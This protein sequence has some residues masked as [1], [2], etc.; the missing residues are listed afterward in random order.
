MAGLAHVLHHIGGGATLG[1]QIAQTQRPT[2]QHLH[3]VGAVRDDERASAGA[4]LTH[5]QRL[6]R[7]RVGLDLGAVRD[8]ELAIAGLAATFG[9]G[10]LCDVARRLECR[11][12]ALLELQ[13]SCRHVNLLL[14]LW[15]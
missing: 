15:I 1:A 9:L 10:L 4:G 12:G 8:A 5:E 2:A 3:N 7:D 6:E 14:I 13:Q 11:V